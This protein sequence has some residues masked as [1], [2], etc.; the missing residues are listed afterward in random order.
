MGTK[1]LII[2]QK[3][4]KYGAMFDHTSDPDFANAEM[5]AKSEGFQILYSGK[6]E[7]REKVQIAFDIID[8]IIKEANQ[9]GKFDQ[10]SLEIKLFECEATSGHSTSM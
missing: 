3:N 5:I 4:G 1:Y 6:I 7:D 9:N 8:E 2:K 10:K